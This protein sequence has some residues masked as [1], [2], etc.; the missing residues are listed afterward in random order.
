MDSL[1]W[2]SLLIFLPLGGGLFVL[3][4]TNAQNAR[5]TALLVALLTFFVSLAILWEFD[6]QKAVFQCI[7]H[8]SWIPSYGI[9]YTLGVDGLSL[10]LIIL[11]TFLML[12]CIIGSWE[13]PKERIKEFLTVF[14]LLESFTLGT[15]C[16]LDLVLFY[17]F[18]EAVLIPMFI[19][20]GI[21]G[22]ANRL[23]ATFK[24]FLFT[25]A[26]SL[27]MLIAL[28]SIIFETGTS[29]L[30]ALS[31]YDFVF[32]NQC[33]LWGAFFLAFAVKIPMIPLHTW[34]PDAHSEAP[35]SGS[36]ILAGV[37][38][39]M[40]GYGLIRFCLGLFPQASLHYQDLILIFSI[41]AVIYASLVAWRQSDIKRLVAYSSIAHMGYVTAGIFLKDVYGLQ[42]SMIQ[43]ISHGLIS[44]ALF[45]CVG[46]VYDRTHTRQIADYGGLIQTMPKYCYALLFFS[47]ASLGLPGTSGFIGEFLV[48]LSAY[49]NN[50]LMAFGLALGMVFS[51]VYML[52]LYKKIAL[53]PLTHKHLMTLKDL[54]TREL[55]LVGV[56]SVLILI[57][58]IY[59]KPLTTL[60]NHSDIFY[61]DK[62]F[63]SEMS[64][65]ELSKNKVEV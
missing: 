34:L 9:S 15:F 54:G 5:Q 6:T 48:I 41:I 57:L 44:G 36:I 39:K 56:L 4:A 16:A 50:G 40:G 22:G 2:L 3:S 27:L 19:I 52:S 11:T 17:V 65:E 46:M 13:H 35:T 61:H 24:F 28:I 59:P 51:A 32:E 63:S 20:I 29:N 38:L 23:K 10:S 45:L 1:P 53:G 49:K 31:H 30:I 7:E 42:G 60:L 64:E 47:M 62:N 14:L 33:L 21:W 26:G 25:L 18:F 12:I 55:S 43:M 37:L 58:G 8:Y